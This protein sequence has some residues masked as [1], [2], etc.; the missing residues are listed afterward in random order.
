MADV[1]TSPTFT[2]MRPYPCTAPGPVRVLLHADLYRLDQLSEVADLGI[3]ELV[4]DDGGG[5]GGVGRRGRR[6]PGARRPHRGAGRRRGR[7]R[8]PGDGH[9]RGAGTGPRGLRWS[10]SRGG[11][12]REGARPRIGHR[13]GRRGHRPRRRGRAGHH[14]AGARPTPR[15]VDHPRRALR[16]HPGRRGPGRRG[17]RGRRRRPRPLHWPPGR[18]G[19]GQGPGLRAR[20]PRRRGEQPRGRWPRRSPPPSPPRRSWSPSS[21]PAG[22][23]CSRP[24]SG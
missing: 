4:E 22:P 3:A 5:R 20:R 11:G 14:H 9:R 17:R 10:G 23:R 8:T 6:H 13:R 15:R 19:H 16:V 21:T 18:G 7:G 1:V 24:G 2:L 12:R